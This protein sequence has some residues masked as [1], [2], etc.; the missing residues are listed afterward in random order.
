MVLGVHL[1]EDFAKMLAAQHQRPFSGAQRAQ[2]RAADELL[3]E[4][5]L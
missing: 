5:R 3:E 4:G 1:G 2:D